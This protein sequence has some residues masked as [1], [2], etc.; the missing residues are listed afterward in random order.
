[1]KIEIWSD[2]VCPFCYMGER[3]LELAL[4]DFAGKNE[5]EIEFR[6]FELS[7]SNADYIGKDIH[8]VIADKY[9][10]SYEEAKANNERI[11]AAAA[12]VGLTYRFDIL[13][14][15]TTRLAH[16]IFQYA[17]KQGK[18]N[19]VAHRFFKAYFEAGVDIGDKEA[20]LS[21]LSDLD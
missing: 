17:K 12:K 19:V 15:N 6:S 20:L 21:L 9:Q 4:N 7:T 13:K 8:Q 10:I 1:M 11:V 3:K 18:G 5:V 16:E 2:F 14:P